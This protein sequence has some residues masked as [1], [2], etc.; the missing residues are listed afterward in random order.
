MAARLVALLGKRQ[1]LR[2]LVRMSSQ[3][4]SDHRS[5]A[6]QHID[7][8]DQSER[9]ASNRVLLTSLDGGELAGPTVGF[10]PRFWKG[11]HAYGALCRARV[12]AALDKQLIS[13][14]LM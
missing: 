10:L 3:R 5:P 1:P 11:S 4:H 8:D 13:L 9:P 6:E 12:P 7:A 14:R 2:Q